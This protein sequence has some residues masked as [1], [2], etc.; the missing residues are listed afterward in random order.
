[1]VLPLFARSSK[2]V[3]LREVDDFI[4]FAGETERTLGTGSELSER[5]STL[6]WP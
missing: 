6:C 1:V 4:A 2:R 3:S 5:R